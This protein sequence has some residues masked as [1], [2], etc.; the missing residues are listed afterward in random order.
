MYWI[1]QFLWFSCCTNAHGKEIAYSDARSKGLIQTNN[2]KH[3]PIDQYLHDRV[4]PATLSPQH[5]AYNKPINPSEM[6]RILT[7]T[8]KITDDTN[9]STKDDQYPWLDPEDKCRH[10]TDAEIL[11]QNL[12]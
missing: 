4:T 5:L 10:M 6:P 7:C 8:N 12:T 11:W 3:F 1:T 9:V 2:S